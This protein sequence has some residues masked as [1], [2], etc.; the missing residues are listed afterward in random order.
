MRVHILSVGFTPK[1]F[2]HAAGPLV[3]FGADKIIAVHT[4]VTE[5][6]KEKVA[7]TIE[8]L[9]KLNV[10][11]EQITIKGENFIDFVET[12]IHLL[13]RFGDSDEIYLHIG[14]G[15]PH[16]RMALVYASFFS[17]KN[18][19]LVPVVEYGQNDEYKYA[20]I[21][22]L[23]PIELTTAQK[24][25]LRLVAEKP[26]QTLRDLAS[27]QNAEAPASTAPGILRHLRRLVEYRLID[28]ER[29][30]KSYRAAETARL[31]LH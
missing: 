4:P 19:K 20:V 8:E 10:P 14:G 16:L 27:R 1:V 17:K 7:H 23:S 24:K 2:T 31:F 29:E 21:P 25:V 3:K 30:T 5:D 26:N 9:S 15:E 11:I 22:P 6:V 13:D 12:F 18:I 28:F